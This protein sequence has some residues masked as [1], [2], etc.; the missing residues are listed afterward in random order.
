MGDFLEHLNSL[1]GALWVKCVHAQSRPT[2]RNPRDGSFLAPLSTGFSRQ[3]YWV[4]CLFLLQEIFPTQGSNPNLP[5]CGQ[6]LYHWA[7]DALVKISRY[8]KWADFHADF[9]LRAPSGSSFS[10][11]AGKRRCV[12]TEP[13]EILWEETP[14]RV[15]LE[16]MHFKVLFF[17]FLR[18]L[19]CHL[20]CENSLWDT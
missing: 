12:L 16:A 13:F 3:E 2:L 8:L 6:I 7:N 20:Y 9:F 10:E 14:G 18:K 15:L 1:H 19:F 5:H 17:F 4:G 11:R